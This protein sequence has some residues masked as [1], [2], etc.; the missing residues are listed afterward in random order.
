[1]I[2]LN[3]YIE[4]E[5]LNS[6]EYFSWQFKDDKINRPDNK[7]SKIEIKFELTDYTVKWI[8]NNE[9]N[10]SRYLNSVLHKTASGNS[11]SAKN[12]IIQYVNSEVIDEKLR[13]KVDDVG[14]GEAIA[15]LDGE[16]YSAC[17]KKKNSY[18]RTRFYEKGANENKTLGAELKFNRGTTWIE[19]ISPEVDVLY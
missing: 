1:M 16:C 11:I 12:I 2:V 13:L 19:A 10:D 15:C 4:A 7:D 5:N 9:K 6:S 3:K 18:A 8:Y 14:T 17:W